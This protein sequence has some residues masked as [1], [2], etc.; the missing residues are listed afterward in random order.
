MKKSDATTVDTLPACWADAKASGAPH[1]FTG[2][3]CKHGHVAQRVTR[4]RNCLEC[5][6]LRSLEVP[7][8]TQRTANRK[9]YGIHRT[10][11]AASVSQRRDEDP[12]RFRAY[13]RQDYRRHKVKRLAHSSAK[14]RQQNTGFT[15]SLFQQ[16]L[17]DQ[18]NKCAICTKALEPGFYTHA[19]HCHATGQTRGVLCRSCN[20]GIGF[21][22]DSP[23]ILLNAVQYL[24]DWTEKAKQKAA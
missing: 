24:L 1:Y 12:E 8:A 10:E 3:P 6:R 7:R 19:D 13:S 11:R 17:Q 18:D 4:T 23:E 2:K 21:L 16:R 20:V 9:S 5:H 14:Q 22:Q 15:P